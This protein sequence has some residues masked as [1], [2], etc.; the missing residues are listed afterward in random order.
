MKDEGKN[1][2]CRLPS[3]V[4]RLPSAVC[5]RDSTASS[6]SLYGPPIRIP[7]RPSWG[8]AWRGKR[9]AG[10]TMTVE[11]RITNVERS[12]NDEA[13]NRLPRPDFWPA[14]D[15]RRVR[16]ARSHRRPGRW[17]PWEGSEGVTEIA[18]RHLVTPSPAH[19]IIPYSSSG[20]P[21]ARRYPAIRPWRSSRFCHWRCWSVT[22]SDR[23]GAWTVSRSPRS[24]RWK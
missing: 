9:P 6:V 1:A 18:P 23:G 13:R 14:S 22:T 11:C 3:A 7:A 4:C 8:H 17:R 12:P 15:R 20:S 5:S 24:R 2:V 16:S 19:P 21:M 10:E